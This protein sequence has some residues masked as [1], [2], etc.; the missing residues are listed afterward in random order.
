MIFEDDDGGE[1]SA[2]ATM[3]RLSVIDASV[4]TACG[5]P[6]ILSLDH[7]QTRTTKSTTGIRLFSIIA[8]CLL[9]Q[10]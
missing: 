3:S 7:N 1:A 8:I 9:Y 5:A 2:L 10:L 6:I 4:F